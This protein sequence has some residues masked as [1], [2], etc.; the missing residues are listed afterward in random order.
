MRKRADASSNRCK[1]AKDHTARRRGQCD[2]TSHA[3]RSDSAFAGSQHGLAPRATGP[4]HWPI[5]L[6]HRIVYCTGSSHRTATGPSHCVC[7]SSLAMIA[8][9][10]SDDS[11]VSLGRD[12]PSFWAEIVVFGLIALLKGVPDADLLTYKFATRSRCMICMYV[13]ENTADRVAHCTAY[14]IRYVGTAVPRSKQHSSNATPYWPRN[15]QM[16]FRST[17]P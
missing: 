7:G 1:N 13:S 17:W 4:S 6:G 11:G 9:A 2:P 10:V 5:A 15:T 8:L 14:G 12:H 3:H 16:N